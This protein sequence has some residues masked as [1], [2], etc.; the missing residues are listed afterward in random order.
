LGY[1]TINV[2]PEDI[3]DKRIVELENFLGDDNK[4]T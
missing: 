1:K 2:I 4:E 3:E